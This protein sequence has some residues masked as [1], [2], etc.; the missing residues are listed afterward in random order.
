MPTSLQSTL[1]QLQAEVLEIEPELKPSFLRLSQ[2]L[3][4]LSLA[5]AQAEQRAARLQT[6]LERSMTL[7]GAE[8]AGLVADEVLDVMV[9]LTGAQRGFV[10]L[11]DGRGDWRF[12]AAREMAEADIHDP[13]GQVSTGIIAAALA[14]EE[15]VLVDDALSGDFAERGS[16]QRLGL[17]SVACLPIRQGARPLGFVYVDNPESTHLFDR[18]ALD[19]LGGWLPLVADHLA[20]ALQEAEEAPFPGFVT[21]STALLAELRELA[22]LARFDVPVLL[23]GPT[24]T[25]KSALARAIHQRSRRADGP[26]IHV[27]CSALPE[28]LVEGELFGAEAGAYTGARSRRVGHFEAANGG[29]LFLDELDT[30]P[31]SAQVKLLVALQERQ[32]TRLGG[33]A[34]I[35]LDL[36]VLAA[37]NAVPR[38]AIAEGRLREDLFFRLAKVEQRLP[39]LVERPED[40]PA[41]A[42]HLLQR[43][44]ETYGLPELRLSG[45]ALDQLC[46]HPWPGNVRELENA[47]DRAALLAGERGLID[48]LRLSTQEDAA[49]RRLS[50]GREEFLQ[51]YAAADERASETARRLGVSRRSVFRL[52]KKYLDD[53][54]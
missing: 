3:Q 14:G 27:N 29:T 39:P 30:M 2:G 32:V 15:A 35:Q 46:A 48:S 37:T 19:A 20:R 41:L 31:I 8:G 4:Q 13:D 5:K 9:A 24:G 7:V 26:F 53:D 40:I 12:L 34:P 49:P 52:K 18:A 54:G 50:V 1:A 16:V 6:L 36:R 23:T 22:R 42:R 47:L 44:R 10:G 25:G 51:A 21:R 17:R 45:A 11:V 33:R 28:G 38:Q 43:A